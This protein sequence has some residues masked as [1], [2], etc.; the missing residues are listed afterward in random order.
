M[1]SV[2]FCACGY[3]RVKL[4]SN[5][6]EQLD[7]FLTSREADPEVRRSPYLA[8]KGVY[9]CGGG[10]V[11]KGRTFSTRSLTSSSHTMLTDCV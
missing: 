11:R 2:H 1:S 9:V 8:M 4:E 10:S 3:W 5:S 7:S 6:R